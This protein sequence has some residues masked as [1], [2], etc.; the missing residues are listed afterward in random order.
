MARTSDGWLDEVQADRERPVPY[1]GLAFIALAAPLCLTNPTWLAAVALVLTGLAH[2]MAAALKEEG[3]CTQAPRYMKMCSCGKGNKG[4]GEVFGWKA[5]WRGADD[6]DDDDDAAADAAPRPSVGERVRE[7]WQ[8]QKEQD[9]LGKIVFVVVFVVVNFVVWITA[10]V[11]WT[12]I[13]NDC[14][15]KL[16]A[17]QWPETMCPSAWAPWAKAFGGSLNFNCT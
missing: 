15:G 10:L 5:V 14:P 1:R 4:A 3:T 12:G 6:G 2:C 7:W 13:I 17:G 8:F 9:E 11:K 16:K